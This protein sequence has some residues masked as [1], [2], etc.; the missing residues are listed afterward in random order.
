M[1][2]TETRLHIRLKVTDAMIPYHFVNAVSL[3]SRAHG[4][5]LFAQ[6]ADKAYP[7]AK[8]EDTDVWLW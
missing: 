1:V 3:R 5:R 7:I 6:T 2:A 4:L 8:M